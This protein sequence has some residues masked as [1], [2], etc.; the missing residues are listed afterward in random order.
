MSAVLWTDTVAVDQ[1][2]ALVP[3]AI[4]CLGGANGPE[5]PTDVADDLEYLVV[6]SHRVDR[7]LLDQ[8]PRLRVVSAWGVGYDHIDVESVRERGIPV[9]INPVFTGAV[10]EAAIALVL[11]LLKRLPELVDAARTG[12]PVLERS[13]V[14]DRNREAAGRTLGVVGFGRIGRRISELAAA[15]GMRVAA[16]DPVLQV[17]SNEQGVPILELHDLL[18]RSDVLVL[19]A[20]LTPQTY[21][22]IAGQE[23][24]QLPVGAIVVNVGRGG[25]VDEV[26]LEAALSSGHLGGAGLD[27][28][29]QEPPA[30]DHPLLSLPTVIGTSH[31]LARSCE[32]LEAILASIAETIERTSRGLAPHH[33][34]D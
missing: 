3:K 22:L 14:G 32:S 6:R 31:N 17:G 28:W 7:P 25:L 30:P 15:L 24:A 8:L 29:E 19:A 4:R 21:H 13:G 5:T 2:Q 20:P 9:A 34:V 18:S 11:G 27:V 23:L 16:V 26:A 12:H 1:L 33:V 10:A